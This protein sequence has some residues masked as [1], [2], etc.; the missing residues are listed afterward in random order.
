MPTMDPIDIPEDAAEAL[1]ALAE[2]L[3][4]VIPQELRF[5][6]GFKEVGG[7]LTDA[8]ALVVFV[9]VKLPPD[10]IPPE[11]FVPAE[12]AGFP[13][14]VVEFQPVLIDDPTCR[15]LALPPDTT[16]HDPLMGGIQISHLVSD[17]ILQ[18]VESGTL[19]AIVRRR[20]DAARLLLTCQHV[21]PTPSD[22]VQQPAFGNPGSTDIG[23]IGLG[24]APRDCAVI[25][26]DGTRGVEATIK[27]VGHVR[28]TAEVRLFE[29]VKK[30]G[31]VTELTS[32][33][34]IHA[35]F[36]PSTSRFE[37]FTVAVVPPGIFCW[38]GDSGSVVLDT[39]DRVLGLLFSMFVTQTDDQGVPIANVGVAKAIKPVQDALGVDI[40]VIPQVTSVAP[41]NAFDLLATFGEVTIDGA[42]FDP[43]SGVTFDTVPALVSTFVGP[44]RMVAT[45]QPSLP[46]SVD[47][48]VSNQFGEVSEAS[49]GSGFTF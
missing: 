23:S 30:R 21:A 19:G 33:R 45:P 39:G 6:V 3:Q 44:D 26:P 28:G 13:T 18:R 20:S 8:I 16:P 11:Q 2:L 10:E 29:P 43:S 38:C 47:V 1:G 12:F 40:A 14:D 17:G 9:P 34:V 46:R 32:G 24:D 37:S 48:H 36:D 27:D 7:E 35:F 31:A 42:G 49:A 4:P 41:N 5:G 15:A 22:P 25:E